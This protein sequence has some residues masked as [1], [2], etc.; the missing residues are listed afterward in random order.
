MINAIKTHASVP[1]KHSANESKRLVSSKINQLRI[2]F[3]MNVVHNSNCKDFYTLFEID[4]KTD[5]TNKYVYYNY[6]SLQ[7]LYKAI[8]TC[9]LASKLNIISDIINIVCNFVGITEFS[10]DIKSKEISIV[11]SYDK[12]IEYAIISL[13]ERDYKHAEY[14]NILLNDWIEADLDENINNKLIYRYIFKYYSIERLEYSQGMYLGIATKS[15]IENKEFSTGRKSLHAIEFS[16]STSFAYIGGTGI[17][18]YCNKNADYAPT[19]WKYFSFANLSRNENNGYFMFELNLYENS[20][21]FYCNQ[22]E[23]DLSNFVTVKMDQILV[24]QMKREPIKMIVSLWLDPKFYE[25]S[26]LGMGLVRFQPS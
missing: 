23:N 11:N 14:H 10:S 1:K 16:H 18:L 24:Q 13:H 7:E 2:K 4:P 25:N 5:E 3:G 22:I 17:R 12:K 9:K 15:V 19:N 21:K 26:K 20:I 8:E 6:Y